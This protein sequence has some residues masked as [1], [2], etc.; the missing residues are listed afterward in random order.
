MA[1]RRARGT[2]VELRRMALPEIA[3]AEGDAAGGTADV[4]QAAGA[5]AAWPLSSQAWP[6]A[7]RLR[8]VK[9]LA[10]GCSSVQSPKAGMYCSSFVPTGAIEGTARPVDLRLARR[11]ARIAAQAG[12]A[13][14][15]F[16]EQA[17][18]VRRRNARGGR[19]ARRSS[20]T[21][22]RR[23]MP[24]MKSFDSSPSN[25]MVCSTRSASLPA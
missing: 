22:K 1:G 7:V 11:G 5:T 9:E 25:T 8:M 10:F 20:G 17:L 6:S 19:A 15:G 21:E 13:A 12:E 2:D 3:D 24:R 18:A 23:P 16:G 4:P 14:H